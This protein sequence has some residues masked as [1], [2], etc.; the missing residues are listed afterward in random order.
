MTETI[1]LQQIRENRGIIY[2]LVN[3]YALHAE[4]KKDLYQEILLQA[5]KGYTSFKGE[6]KFSTWLYRIS[7]N[8]LLTYKR[9]KRIV[10]Y[11]DA[12]EHLGAV[13]HPSTSTDETEALYGAIR[14]LPETDRAIISLHLDGYDNP[15][16]AEIIGITTN[17][18]AVKMHR[19]KQHLQ[20]TLKPIYH[21]S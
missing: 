20:K 8:T 6:A 3:L 7:L 1:F 21:E 12:P 18:V 5:W 9:K 16:I 10:D 2:K 19:I 13:P 17:H 11:T 15:E 4:E 14:Q